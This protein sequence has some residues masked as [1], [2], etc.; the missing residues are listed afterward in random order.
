[1]FLRFWNQLTIPINIA[2]KMQK[3]IFFTL[4][5]DLQRHMISL[6]NSRASI[7]FSTLRYRPVLWC[8]DL[9]VHATLH[10]SAV[11]A[12]IAYSRPNALRGRLTALDLR[13]TI[14]QLSMIIA[15]MNKVHD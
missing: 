7:S 1:M 5:H 6:Q 14:A 11:I 3:H 13:A 12:N 2:Q 9:L 15:R 4:N 8:G 10:P